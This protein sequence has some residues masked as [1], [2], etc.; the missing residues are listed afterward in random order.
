MLYHP[1]LGGR[2]LQ[3]NGENVKKD[4]ARAHGGSPRSASFE[5]GSNNIYMFSVFFLCP[6]RRSVLLTVPVVFEAWLGHSVRVE[7]VQNAVGTHHVRYT[8]T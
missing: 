5:S 7:F 6:S 8:G 1:S 2:G 4:N 3:T